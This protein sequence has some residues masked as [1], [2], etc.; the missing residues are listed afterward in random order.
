MILLDYKNLSNEY[1]VVVEKENKNSPDDMGTITIWAELSPSGANNLSKTP[2][3]KNVR[4]VITSTDIA[5]IR[6]DA[7]L[8]IE[9]DIIS[10]G[11][12]IFRISKSNTQTINSWLNKREDITTEGKEL[13]DYQRISQR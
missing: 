5:K 8:A 11:D 2:P 3:N 9:N 10:S 1:V 7:E 6:K 12:T 13:L 4:N